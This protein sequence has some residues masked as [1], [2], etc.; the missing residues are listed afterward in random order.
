MKPILSHSWHTEYYAK[1]LAEIA[2][3][4]GQKCMEEGCSGWMEWFKL[5]H[6]ELFKKLENALVLITN[7]WGSMKPADMEAFKKAVQIEVDAYAFAIPKYLEAR[8]GDSANRLA[9]QEATA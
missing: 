9:G 5:N 4:T 6:P 3:T 7:L 2:N 8:R 1:K